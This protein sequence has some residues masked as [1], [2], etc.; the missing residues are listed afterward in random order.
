M[1][2]LT[3][4]HNKGVF[5]LVLGRNKLVVAAK[6][7][8]EATSINGIPGVVYPKAPKENVPMM[9]PIRAI[10]KCIPMAV[11]L[12]FEKKSE[13]EASPSLQLFIVSPIH[14]LHYSTI[15]LQQE[16]VVKGIL[17]SFPPPSCYNMTSS[18]LQQLFK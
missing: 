6:N 12:R 16:V 4:A 17:A 3:E 13:K 7:S 15:T 5:R 11:D 14:P 18:I 2:K 10:S 9:A 1:Q 8:R